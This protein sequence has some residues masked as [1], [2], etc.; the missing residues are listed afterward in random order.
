MD[1]KLLALM[2]LF[3]LSF[4]FFS[5]M[6][7]FNKPI[8]QFTRAREDVTP[9]INRSKIIAWPFPIIKADGISESTIN[10]FII[11]ESGIPLSNKVVTL[12]SSFGQLRESAVSTD[13]NGKA[14]F[15]ITAST[16]GI[17]DIEAIVEPSLKLSQ[18]LS[19]KFE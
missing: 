5:I 17:A 19:L 8:T 1:K 14:A 6:T 18:K 4:A 10:V 7:V 13:N 16:P 15:K 11:S 9:S 12:V 2:V 3:F